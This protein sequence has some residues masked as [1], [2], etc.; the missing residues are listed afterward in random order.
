MS[1]AI[2]SDKLESLNSAQ[3]EHLKESVETFLS[4]HPNCSE[5]EFQNLVNAVF[6]YLK[7]EKGL[8]DLGS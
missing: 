8:E 6:D 4:E 5:V 1:Y 2:N 3:F 7:S